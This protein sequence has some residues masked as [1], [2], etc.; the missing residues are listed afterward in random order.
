MASRWPCSRW[1]VFGF[2]FLLLSSASLFAW[3]GRPFLWRIEGA[4]VTSYAFG[5]VHLGD[6]RLRILPPSVN[7]AFERSDVV[8]TEISFDPPALSAAHR[9]SQAPPGEGLLQR[10]PADLY[11]DAARALAAIDEALQLEAYDGMRVWAFATEL[12]TFEA[13]LRYPFAVSMDYQLY[14]RAVRDGREVRALESVDEQ[15]AV[16]REMTASQEEAMLRDTL[17][18]L[19]GARAE[20]SDPMDDLVRIYLSGDGEALAAQLDL[21][22]DERS[23]ENEHLLDAVITQR[24]AVMAE[25]MAANLRG[26]PNRVHFFAVGA[27][28]FLSSAGILYHLEKAGFVVS[29]V[30]PD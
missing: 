29:R 6:P 28:H 12:I 10:L 21:W 14:Q 20:G 23:P 1:A 17:A 13:R 30:E 27:A 26:E 16:F 24:D 15:L 2:L 22:A 19:D 5:T 4:E 7:A 8:Y 18:H 11:A 9:A 3:E 25:R